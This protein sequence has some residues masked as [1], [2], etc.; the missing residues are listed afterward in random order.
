M[1]SAICSA[2]CTSIKPMQS[3]HVCGPLKVSACICKH[4]DQ[5]I[6]PDSKILPCTCRRTVLICH[7]SRNFLFLTELSQRWCRSRRHLWKQ[8]RCVCDTTLD[9]SDLFPSLFWGWEHS[10]AVFIP[11][12]STPQHSRFWEQVKALHNKLT[13][14]TSYFR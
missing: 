11:G 13:A 5:D 12:W 9:V 6:R 4:C 1:P 2:S 3:Q 10:I 14:T 7:T 8:L